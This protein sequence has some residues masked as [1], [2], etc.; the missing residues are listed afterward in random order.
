LFPVDLHDWIT[1]H[2]IDRADRSNRAAERDSVSDAK[3][4]AN[5]DFAR[6]E[7]AVALARVLINF[8]DD[9]RIHSPH[10]SSGRAQSL[11]VIDSPMPHGFDFT[12]SM[13][14]FVDFDPAA[15]LDRVFERL[16]DGVAQTM[17]MS[18]YFFHY[19]KLI[20]SFGITRTRSRKNLLMQHHA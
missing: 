15:D 14:L 8:S 2:Q 17:F 11:I 9:V 10:V 16:A 18:D 5:V 19:E 20:L 1:D 6:P 7:A 12:L 3:M 13:S 4:S